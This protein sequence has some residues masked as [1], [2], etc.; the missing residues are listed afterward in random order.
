MNL[1]AY[2]AYQAMTELMRPW[3][4][5]ASMTRA[6]IAACPAIAENP[7]GRYVDACCE[8]IQLAGLSHH[9]P[10][11]DIPDEIGRAHV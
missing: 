2:P 8:L 7:Q 11:F 9:R 3:R 6:A 1:F 5:A 4:G 10:P